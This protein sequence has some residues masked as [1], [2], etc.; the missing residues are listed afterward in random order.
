MAKRRKQPARRKPT[1]R[2]LRDALERVDSLM[3]RRRWAEARELLVDLD[4]TYPQRQEVLRALVEAALH[5]VR[6]R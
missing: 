3:A 2:R 1:D 6:R 5:P 4:Q